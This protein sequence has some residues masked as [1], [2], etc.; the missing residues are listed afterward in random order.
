[1]ANQEELKRRIEA[2]IQKGGQVLATSRQLSSKSSARI[3]DASAFNDWKTQSLSFLMQ[4]RGADD[5]YTTRFEKEVHDRYESDVKSGIGI[6][7]ALYEDLDFTSQVLYNAPS[8]Q[9]NNVFVVHGHDEEMKQAGARTLSRLGLQPIILHEQPNQGKTLIEKFERSADV[10]FAVILLSPDDMGYVKTASSESAQARPRQNVILELGYF[11]GK[12]TRER[13]FA[14]KR[15]GDLELPNDIAGLV[16]TPYDAAGHWRF[17]LV[18]EL[19]AAGHTVD[20]NSLI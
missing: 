3:L 14:L 6:L 10:Q 13:V 8:A 4:L 9:T 5:V 17:E 1:V 19:K 11:V 18:R 7:K 2:L 15:E 12:L 16:Y 20:A